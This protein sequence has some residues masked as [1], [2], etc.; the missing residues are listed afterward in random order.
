MESTT[1]IRR[2]SPRQSALSVRLPIGEDGI[3]SEVGLAIDASTID[4][5]RCCENG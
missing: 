2:T 1:L 5:L 4:S 3:E